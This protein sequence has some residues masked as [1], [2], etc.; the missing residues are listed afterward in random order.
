MKFSIEWYIIVEVSFKLWQKPWFTKILIEFNICTEIYRKSGY[1]SLKPSKF[2]ANSAHRARRN[3]DEIMLCRKFSWRSDEPFGNYRANGRTDIL[4]DSR[5]YSL[6]EYTKTR[7]PL[8]EFIL[9]HSFEFGSIYEQ[10]QF[11]STSDKW[12]QLKSRSW[13]QWIDLYL[14]CI[15]V[16][17]FSIDLLSFS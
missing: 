17:L 10:K 11:F 12:R 2:W 13:E 8:A 1:C 7:N 15:W 9:L 4:T 3:I 6:F 16:S 5:V 14:H